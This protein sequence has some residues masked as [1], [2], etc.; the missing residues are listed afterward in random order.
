M[1][2]RWVG[3]AG[4]FFLLFTFPLFLGAKANLSWEDQARFF[5]WVTAI[6]GLILGYIAAALYIPDARKAV[7]RRSSR[8]RGRG[9]VAP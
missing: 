7:R 6:P 9:G 8:A 4:T 2:V 5:A 3:K 1:D